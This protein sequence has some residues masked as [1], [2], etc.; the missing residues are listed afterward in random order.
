MSWMGSSFLTRTYYV[1]DRHLS[2]PRSRSDMLHHRP[3][4][5]RID[6]SPTGFRCRTDL[7]W[8]VLS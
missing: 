8:D 2:L 3:Q 4:G 6:G 5:A 1:I 7:Q